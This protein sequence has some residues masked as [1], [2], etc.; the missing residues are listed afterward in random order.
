MSS[1]K[2]QKKADQNKT[3]IMQSFTYNG[4]K[5]YEIQYRLHNIKSRLTI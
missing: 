1:P 2:L 3:N 5:Q 4:N